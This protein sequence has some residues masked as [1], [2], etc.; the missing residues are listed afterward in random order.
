MQSRPCDGVRKLT[1]YSI[2]KRPEK[3]KGSRI[4]VSAPDWYSFYVGRPHGYHAMGSEQSEEEERKK[5]KWA[6]NFNGLSTQCAD[7]SKVRQGYQ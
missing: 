4:G 3:Y 5:T 2:S 1:R 6:L 7:Y